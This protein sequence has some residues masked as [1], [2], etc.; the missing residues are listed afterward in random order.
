MWQR[1]HSAA[2]AALQQAQ[3]AYHRAVADDACGADPS[4]LLTHR[5]TLEKLDAARRH[6][7]EVRRRQPPATGPRHAYG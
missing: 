1:E 3:R 4:A 5:M 2:L 6:L 7:D